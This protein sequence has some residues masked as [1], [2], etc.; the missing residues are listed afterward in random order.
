M[1]NIVWNK[2]TWYSKMIAAAIFV[3]LP[4]VGFYYGIQYGEGIELANQAVQASPG[5]PSSPYYSNVG[6]WQTAQSTNGGFSI[7]YPIDFTV[8]QNY[9][10]AASPNWRIGAN[11]NPGNLYLTITVPAAFEPQTNFVSAQLTVGTS[12]N[13]KAIVDCLTPD[14][15]G[16]PAVPTSTASI[17]GIQ[18]T[19]FKSSDAGAGNYYE[20]TSYRTLHAGQCYAVE[21]TVHSSQIGNY[22]P[23]YDLQPVN[24]DQVDS[25]LDRIVGTFQFL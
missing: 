4:F 14:P 20:T 21:Y 18:F 1:A 10:T 12:R 2:V 5:T 22:P 8:D 17:N 3:I 7:A 24:E 15:T 11:G 25:L 19:V 16:S 6:E 13:N 9:S 23:Q